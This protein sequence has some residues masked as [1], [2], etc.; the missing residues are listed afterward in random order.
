VSAPGWELAPDDLDDLV[1]GVDL[2]PIDLAD[3]PQGVRNAANK[4]HANWVWELRTGEGR[5]IRQAYGEP[6]GDGTRPQLRVLEPCDTI[7]VRA[8]AA[9]PAF[10][11]NR[12]HVVIVWTRIERTGKRAPD[13]AWAWSCEPHPD[14]AGRRAWSRAPRRVGV[15]MARDLLAAPPDDEALGAAYDAAGPPSDDSEVST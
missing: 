11:V 6:R 7:S 14:G 5:A 3:A 10:P 8:E 2:G 1:P 13:G 12:L 15:T 4:I 9:D